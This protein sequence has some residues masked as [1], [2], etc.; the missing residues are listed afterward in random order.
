MASE[1]PPIVPLSRLV[2]TLFFLFTAFH[3]LANYEAVRVVTMETLNKA[4]LH[5]LM[6]SFLSMGT[7]PS[8]GVV[9]AR[10]PI[11]LRTCQYV[12]PVPHL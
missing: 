7:I 10:E 12:S 9:N 2:W 11:L 6:T 8:V 3:L 5:I 4:R 1:L